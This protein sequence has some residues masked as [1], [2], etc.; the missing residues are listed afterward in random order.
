MLVV[1]LKVKEFMMA[2]YLKLEEHTSRL[3]YSA[4][5]MGFEIPYQKQKLILLQIK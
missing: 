5:R 1:F 2:Q 3:F 4:K